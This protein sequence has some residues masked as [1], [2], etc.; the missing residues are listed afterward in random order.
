MEGRVLWSMMTK[1][2]TSPVNYQVLLLLLSFS[3]GW[4]GRASACNVGDPGSI[5]GSGRSPGEGNG[6]PLQY[7][8]LENPMDRGAWWTIVHGVAELDTT[9]WLL[10]TSRLLFSQLLSW[11]QLFCHPIDS[12][13]PGSSVHGISKA[14]I[15]EW[16]AISFSRGSSQPRDRNRVSCIAGEF[17][18]T[19]LPGKPK[20]WVMW[21]LKEQQGIRGFI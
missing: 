14:R 12:S 18:T 17:F 15:P 20:L 4:E 5:P 16:V 21:Y 13:P 19:E 7:P 1:T 10:F 2:I 3:G 11:V 6:N 9:E 8:C